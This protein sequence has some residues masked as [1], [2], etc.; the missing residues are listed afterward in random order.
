MY[1][2]MNQI[3][4]KTVTT[5]EKLQKTATQAILVNQLLNKTIGLFRR[6][7]LPEQIDSI[8][9]KMQRLMG[10]IFQ[11]R[12]AIVALNAAMIGTPGGALIAGISFL[13]IAMDVGDL[14][15]S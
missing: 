10:I 2:L 3:E 15:M 12:L 11:V 13:M 8:V 9:F 1:A 4:N 7:G 6:M 14:M 5:E